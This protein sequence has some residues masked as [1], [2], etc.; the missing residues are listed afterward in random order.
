MINAPD[1]AILHSFIQLTGELKAHDYDGTIGMYCRDVDCHDCVLVDVTDCVNECMHEI[2]QACSNVLCTDY[3]I[4]ET[5]VEAF[6]ILPMI[7]SKLEE[8]YPEL[9]I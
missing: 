9:W 1:F 6:V 5:D 8:R 2:L 4:R 7:Q 3:S